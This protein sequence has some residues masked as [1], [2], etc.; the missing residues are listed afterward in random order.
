[1]TALALRKDA[2]SGERIKTGPPHPA[3]ALLGANAD[4]AKKREE[5]KIAATGYRRAQAP[6]WLLS[7]LACAVGLAAF[8]A[9]WALIAKYGG[10]G[11]RPPPARAAAPQPLS[12]APLNKR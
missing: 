1:M 3:A 12:G 5:A 4:A 7:A 2:R 6:E 10:G 11:P 8:V 9:V